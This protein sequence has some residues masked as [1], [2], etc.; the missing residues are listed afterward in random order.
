MFISLEEK[1]NPGPKAAKGHS[2]PL[3]DGNASGGER[4][5]PMLV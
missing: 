4:P 2:T 1:Q 5:T 3:L